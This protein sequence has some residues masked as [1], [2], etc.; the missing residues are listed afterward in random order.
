MHGHLNRVWFFRLAAP[1]LLFREVLPDLI[2]TRLVLL[3]LITDRLVV[4]ICL[5]DLREEVI[6]R[7]LLVQRFCHI[8]KFLR[9][10]NVIEIQFNVL[11]F[12]WRCFYFSLWLWRLFDVKDWF[13]NVLNDCNRLS[14]ILSLT[15]LSRIFIHNLGQLFICRGIH[16]E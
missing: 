8:R 11:N 15:W 4:V 14:N 12:D 3:N 10:I 2:R 6:E 13:C 1:A 5:R 9:R 7:G 16:V